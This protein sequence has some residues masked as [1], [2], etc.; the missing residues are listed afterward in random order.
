MSWRD[1]L[2]R[3]FNEHTRLVVVWFF[4]GALAAM[5]VAVATADLFA[6]LAMIAV[7]LVPVWWS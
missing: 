2:G 1:R 6:T 3:Y 4:A 5:L 7:A